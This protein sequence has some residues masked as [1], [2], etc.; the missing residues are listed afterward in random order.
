MTNELI[1]H[2]GKEGTSSTRLDVA[3]FRAYFC[4]NQN[5]LSVRSEDYSVIELRAKIQRCLANGEN[6]DAFAA[7]LEC[8]ERI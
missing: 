5:G 2:I 6:V 8:L 7:A 4:W 3:P 1:W